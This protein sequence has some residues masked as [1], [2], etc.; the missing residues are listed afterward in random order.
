MFN[1]RPNGPRKARNKAWYQINLEEHFIK[2]SS[3]KFTIEGTK[4]FRHTLTEWKSSELDK[5]FKMKQKNIIIDYIHLTIY[6]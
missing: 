4:A 3:K 1:F 2:S 5:Q 6:C